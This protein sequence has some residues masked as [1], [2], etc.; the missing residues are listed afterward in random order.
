MLRATRDAGA[1]RVVLTSSFAAVGYTPEPSADYTEA[2]WTEPDTPGLLL[3]AFQGDR[4]AR[5]IQQL[6]ARPP[7]R[8]GWRWPRPC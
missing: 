5:R 4:G 7:H 6:V 2:D 1:R 3:P 8:N